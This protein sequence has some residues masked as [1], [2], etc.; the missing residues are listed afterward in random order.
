MKILVTGGTGMLGSRLVEKMSRTD[1]VFVF[2]RDAPK[3]NIGTGIKIVFGDLK[4]VDDL[5]S[6]F[7]KQKF[8]AVYHLAANMDESDPK[9]YYENVLG[10]KYVIE[11]CRKH[12]VKRLVFM[13][14]CG[15]TG[16]G[17]VSKEDSPYRPNTRYEKSKADSEKLV[18]DSGLPYAII[19][20]PIIIGP[21]SMW[22]KIAGA[23]I[24]KYPVIGSG[25]NHF[26][27]AY[28]DDVVS[29]LLLVKTGSKSE[30]QV[31]NV[32]TKD[33]KTY[34]EV[35]EIICRE[36]KIRKTEKHVPIFLVMAAAFLHE[37]ASKLTGKKPKLTMMR[38]SI[39]RLIVERVVSTEKAKQVLGFV[40]EYN[41]E[42][43]VRNAISQLRDEKM[44]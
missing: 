6:A 39:K 5:E 30:N 22:A 28:V 33:V 42:S 11:A 18:R 23:A 44:L 37:A 3:K 31:F 38:S 27:L 43:A 20:A 19:R 17:K 29:L 24:K 4:S 13:G 25:K 26:H 41:T 10:T 7:A 15:A 34:S 35:Y 40:P 1:D 16:Y 36:L 9:M 2:A 12:G 32:A 14:S 21:N 8:D